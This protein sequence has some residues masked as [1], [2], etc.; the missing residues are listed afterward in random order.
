MTFSI[1]GLF[2]KHLINRKFFSLGIALALLGIAWICSSNTSTTLNEPII[3]LKSDF[4]NVSG[5]TPSGFPEIPQ[6]CQ[7]GVTIAALQMNVLY[8]GIENRLAISVPCSSEKVQASMT[9]GQ[10]K[11][12]DNCYW[13]AIPRTPGEQFINVTANFFPD[14]SAPK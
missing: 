11:K 12:V 10:I 5:M 2:P 13:I 6:D 3:Q 14:S 9:D 8:V 1:P 7:S 4:V